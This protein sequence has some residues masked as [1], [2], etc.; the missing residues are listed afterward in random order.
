MEIP[1]QQTQETPPQNNLPPDLINPDMWVGSCYGFDKEME[2]SA[3]LYELG[4]T[5]EEFIAIAWLSRLR[6][7]VTR[8]KLS[9]FITVDGRHRA[10]KSRA[11]AAI[12]CLFS[13]A[14][15]KNMRKFIVQDADQLLNL[16]E[17]IDTKKIKNP[18]IIID[19]AGSSLNSGDWY[20]AISKSVIKTMTILGYL[21]PTIFFL[22]PL[23]GLIL[24]GIR[25][26]SHVHIKMTR[27][28]NKYAVMVPYEILFNTLK[29]KPYFRKFRIT[30]FGQPKIISHVRITLPPGDIDSEYSSIEKER[31]PLMLKDIRED[32]LKSKIKVARE[33]VDYDNIAEIVIGQYEKFSLSIKRGGKRLVNAQLIRTKFKLSTQDANAIQAIVNKRLEQEDMALKPAE[34]KESEERK[35]DLKLEDIKL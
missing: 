14:F 18:V 10:G 9:L 27:G 15:R 3:H 8:T 13:D 30:L 1:P 33:V 7:Q 26:M 20:E 6:A 4:F 16:I 34:Q 29:N 28:S 5:Q 23:K 32:S 21:R 35:K 19:E 17:E 24:S 31:K 25:N 12:A 11:I 2:P 22:A